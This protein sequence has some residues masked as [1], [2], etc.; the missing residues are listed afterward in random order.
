MTHARSAAPSSTAGFTLVELLVVL[1]ILGMA[2]AIALPRLLQP[3]PALQL[4]AAVRALIGAMRSTRSA[5]IAQNKELVFVLD[6][7]SRSFA[8]PVAREQALPRDAQMALKIAEP[9][10]ESPSRGGIRFYPD[11]SASGGE[12][13]LN[14]KDKEGRICIH[15]LTG[16]PVEDGRC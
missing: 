5:A 12:I 16:Q 3:S 6:V 14:L 4:D 15:W 9:E 8:S 13:V 2:M 11:G 7:N 10:R 1:A